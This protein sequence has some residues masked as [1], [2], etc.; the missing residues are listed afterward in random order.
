MNRRGSSPLAPVWSLP[1][2]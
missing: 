1:W 2:T